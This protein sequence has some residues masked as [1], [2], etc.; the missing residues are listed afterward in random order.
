MKEIYDILEFEAITYIK[1]SDITDI[2]CKSKIIGYGEIISTNLLSIFL[3][4]QNIV[5]TLLNSY[6]YIKS[7]KEI[8]QCTTQTE[9]Y[10]LPIDFNSHPET[11]IF[12]Q[13]GYIG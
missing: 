1:S 7:K 8:Y 3:K 2:Y 4:K 10:A 9:F 11:N 6:E 12:I 13:Q 5:N